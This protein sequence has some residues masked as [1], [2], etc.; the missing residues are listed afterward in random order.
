MKLLIPSKFGKFDFIVTRIFGIKNNIN[1]EF[2]FEKEL[3][4]AMLQPP[5]KLINEY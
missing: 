5:S 4:S 1:T 3:Y 2:E